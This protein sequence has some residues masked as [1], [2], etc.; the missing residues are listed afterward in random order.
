[1]CIRPIIVQRVNFEVVRRIILWR[2]VHIS[3]QNYV[4]HLEVDVWAAISSDD[5]WIQL[6]LHLVMQNVS[7]DFACYWCF[8]EDPMKKRLFSYNLRSTYMLYYD[9]LFFSNRA[10]NQL[11]CSSKQC[12]KVASVSN[13]ALLGESSTLRKVSPTVS[14]A[15]FTRKEVCI[16]FRHTRC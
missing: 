16:H 11:E 15:E 13:V 14:K 6:F 7:L 12:V 2:L 9:V 1:M 4:V 3:L 5:V 8:H 10:M